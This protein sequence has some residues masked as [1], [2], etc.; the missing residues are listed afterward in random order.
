MQKIKIWFRRKY[1]FWKYKHNNNTG[2]V[3]IT[4]EK[5]R[6]LGLTTLMLNDCIKNG[7][8]LLVP[9]QID[10]K[11]LAYKLCAKEH[12]MLRDA[13]QYLMC[14]S[15]NTRAFHRDLKIVVDNHCSFG[16]ISEVMATTMGKIVNGFVYCP[17]AA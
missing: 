5:D 2:K 9:N 13:E 8:V 6:K 12:M 11:R 16:D 14:P 10:K 4:K 17:Y 15:D 3:I 7:Y 1:L